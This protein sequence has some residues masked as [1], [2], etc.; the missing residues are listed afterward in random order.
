M[1]Y[2]ELRMTCLKHWKG[3]GSRDML[4]FLT[5]F[6]TKC[7]H[8]VPLSRSKMLLM[9]LVYIGSIMTPVGYLLFHQSFSYLPV[10]V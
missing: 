1:T 4:V 2:I 8:F 7:G 3:K 9:T 10:A 5:V 6:F